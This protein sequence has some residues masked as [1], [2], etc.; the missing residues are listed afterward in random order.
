MAAQ[1]AHLGIR[2]LRE[3]PLHR[4]SHRRKAF[5]SHR[6]KAFVGAAVG[7]TIP[8]ETPSHR[9][10]YPEESLLVDYIPTTL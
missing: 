6:V 7:V 8:Q 9:L 10:R 3:R 2:Q 5:Y 1:R 4:E